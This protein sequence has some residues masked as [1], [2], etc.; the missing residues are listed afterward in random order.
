MKKWTL[1]HLTVIWQL[2]K[3]V[4]EK[5]KKFKTW[6]I[7][8]VRYTTYKSAWGGGCRM[9]LFQE[10]KCFWRTLSCL[11]IIV[12]RWNFGARNEIFSLVFLFLCDNALQKLRIPLHFTKCNL[13][14]RTLL[15]QGIW[16][17]RVLWENWAQI[18]P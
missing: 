7:N 5:H 8:D 12:A 3:T 13:L 10:I 4:R 16:G 15:F 14:I 11:N 2:N 1:Q 9:R 17:I 18:E 6:K